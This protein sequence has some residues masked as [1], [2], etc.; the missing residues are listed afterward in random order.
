MLHRDHCRQDLDPGVQGRRAANLHM[1][2]TG[3]EMLLGN[4]RRQRL[5]QRVWQSVASTCAVLLLAVLDMPH[6]LAARAQ[7]SA[8]TM[9]S[10]VAGQALQGQVII[11]GSTGA[12]NFGSAEVAFAYA[13]D[14]SNTWFLIQE[15]TQPVTDGVL[16]TWDTTKITDGAY[17]LRLRVFRTDGSQQDAAAP[18]ELANYSAPAV[19]TDTPVPTAAPALELPAPFVISASATPESLAAATPTPL[20]PNPASLPT[21]S[22]YEGLGR[23][24]FIAVVAII[25]LGTILLRRRS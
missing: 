11:S 19:T 6:S 24:A 25:L 4:A 14:P 5:G 12:L 21:A 1:D 15:L 16:A 13:S 23:G 3:S 2:S 10:P 18:V 8:P 7:E 17:V 9:S 22:I 20:P